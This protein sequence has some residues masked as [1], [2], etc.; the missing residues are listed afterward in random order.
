MC[1]QQQDMFRQIEGRLYWYYETE[2]K[3]ELM[4]G[5]IERFEDRRLKLMLLRR[6]YLESCAYQGAKAQ[7]G[8]ERTQ[9]KKSI[10]SNPIEP[11]VDAVTDLNND[12]FLLWEK[13]VKLE[14]IIGERE[15]DM[16]VIQMAISYLAHLDRQICLFKY[17]YKMSFDDIARSVNMSKSGVRHR[18]RKIVTYIADRLAGQ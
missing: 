4:R 2:R 10:Y 9:G 16:A 12:I 15:R 8:A 5:H 7:Y 18:R 17:K 3:L 13:Q 14:K 6:E 1:N 11:A